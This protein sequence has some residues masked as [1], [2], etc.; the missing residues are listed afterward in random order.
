MKNQ[1][2]KPFPGSVPTIT[3]SLILGFALT[4]FMPGASA[5]TVSFTFAY[6]CNM[7][8]GSCAEFSGLSTASNTG[9]TSAETGISIAYVNGHPVTGGELSYVSAPASYA[10]QDMFTWGA[11]YDNP[12]GSGSIKGSV[13]GLGAGSTL[14]T[15]TGFLP[16][17]RSGGTADS[18]SQEYFNDGFQ[19]FI[20]PT[21]LSALGMDPSITFGRGYLEDYYVF[22]WAGDD[23]E[24]DIGATVYFTPT[25][26]PGTLGLFGTAVVGLAG[27]LRR[28]WIG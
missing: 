10:S 23:G 27:V 26:E 25:P 22:Y 13:F 9:Q 8:D 17:G 2:Y 14:L 15:I 1:I 18:V 4:M 7:Y 5:S 28:R 24:Y 19:G 3:A 6:T 16:G 12:G 21:I 11:L 20:N